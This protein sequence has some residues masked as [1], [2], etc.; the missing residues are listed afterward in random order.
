MNCRSFRKFV[1]AFTDGELDTQANAEALEHLNMCPDCAA[2]VGGVQHMKQALAR[3]FASET[4]PAGLTDRIQQLLHDAGSTAS[5]SIPVS[6]PQ[7]VS[8]GRHRSWR[9]RI[10]VPLSMAAAVVT[11][12][13]A[14]QFFDSSEPMPGSTT[15]IRG[16]FASATR[17]LHNHCAGFGPKHHDPSLGRDPGKIAETLSDRLDVPVIVPDLSR[18]GY[19]MLGADRCGI[20]RRRGGHAL[21]R[22]QRDG[23]M[24]SVFT[25]VVDDCGGIPFGTVTRKDKHDFLVD[26]GETL[27]AAGWVD[28][29]VAYVLCGEADVDGLLDIAADLR[30]P[31]PSPCP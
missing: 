14:W 17:K 18:H 8:T 23:R 26:P 7:P 6:P 22:R 4:A 2:R 20:E 13:G 12:V 30:G 31:A 27:S 29:C 9:H 19:E 15:T 5:T 1:G 3:M 11:A 21:Y 10:L 28:G 24:L 25:V 16:R